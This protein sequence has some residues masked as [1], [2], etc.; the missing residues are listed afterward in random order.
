[1]PTLWRAHLLWPPGDQYAES[2]T[3]EARQERV[4]RRTGLQKCVKFVEEACVGGELLIDLQR[5]R[6]ATP[7]LGC[8]F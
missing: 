8:C 1:M 7:F 4:E 6:R 5:K 3:E 2:L